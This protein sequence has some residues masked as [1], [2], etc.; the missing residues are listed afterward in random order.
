MLCQHSFPELEKLVLSIHMA[1]AYTLLSKFPCTSKI[2]F[3]H[4]TR[5]TNLLET[6]SRGHYGKETAITFHETAR[7]SVGSNMPA[8]SLELKHI[9]RLIQELDADIE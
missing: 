8:K 3:A 6:S 4:L 7:M 1:S 5:L 9:I 2:A